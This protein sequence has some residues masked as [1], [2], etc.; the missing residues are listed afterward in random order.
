MNF[1]DIVVGV[2]NEEKYIQKCIKS[3]QNQTIQDIK[4]LVVDGI[5]SDRTPDIIREIAEND[6]RVLLLRNPREVISSA[7]NIGLEASDA[8][9]VAY[10][11]GHCYVDPD[12]LEKLLETYQKYEKRCKLGGVGSTYASPDN[13][14]DLGKI[15]AKALQ[16]PF[17]GIGTAFAQ[18]NTIKKVE[19]V[20][21]TLYPR[22]LLEEEDLLYDETMSHCEDTDFNYQLI[23]KGYQLLQNPRALVYQYRRDTLE[24]FFQQM[25][26]YG[27]GR[28]NFT[29]KNPRTFHWY[30]IIPTITIF[31]FIIFMITLIAYL[32]SL[33]TQFTIL[34][35][36]T[37]IAM[38]F[39]IDI[40]YTLKFGQIKTLLVFPLEHIGYGWGFLKGILMN[41]KKLKGGDFE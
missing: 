21:F 24:A 26:N 20:A 38:Y 37:P 41:N 36:F 40:Y 17:G 1:I 15:I 23:K 11:D 30:H 29:I 16:T 14:S 4:I 25:V 5:S 8:E 35:I 12:W 10:L 31:Y 28:A 34:I 9:Y 3:L 6:S 32:N 33:I 7:R 19:T 2:K 22:F 39:L 13:D 27:E 18:E